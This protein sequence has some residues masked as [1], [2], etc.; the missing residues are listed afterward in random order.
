MMCL[1]TSSSR[2]ET[3]AR[4][5][6]GSSAMILLM[7]LISSVG[8]SRA[9]LTGDRILMSGTSLRTFSLTKLD[10]EDF[11]DKLDLCLIRSFSPP[12]STPFLFAL[13]F[14]VL[15]LEVLL[16]MM[17][18]GLQS[19]TSNASRDYY[20]KCSFSKLISYGFACQNVSHSVLLPELQLC[21]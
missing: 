9:V 17:N 5:H 6:S 11:S 4:V 14:L 3:V 18:S 10:D 1:R 12:G 7:F 20:V 15:F 21:L 8:L 2:E 19:A 13:P 16:L